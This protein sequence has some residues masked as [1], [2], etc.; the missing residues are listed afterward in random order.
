MLT[1]R[2]AVK[3]I[4]A[5]MAG[6]LIPQDYQMP[7]DM[8]GKRKK[9]RPEDIRSG[10]LYGQYQLRGSVL[11]IK[12]ASTTASGYMAFGTDMTTIPTS[13]TTGTGIYIDYTGIYGLASNVQ[14]AYMSAAD[15]KIYAGAGAVTLD[16]TGV[17]VLS[18]TSFSD[19]NSF[20][21]VESDGTID[22]LWQHY[23]NATTKNESLLKL[24]AL[25]GLASIFELNA[26]APST[27]QGQISLHTNSGT[28]DAYIQLT[29]T[30]SSTSR[31][32]LLNDSLAIKFQV[33]LV[34]D[35]VVCNSAAIATNATDGFL[36]IATCAGTPTGTPTTYTGRAPLV[37]DSTNNKL[38]IY[39][40][41][42]WVAVN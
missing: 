24:N 12:D 41:G 17:A 5:A 13:A 11:T 33:D 8:K 16:S 26:A 7:E 29:T 20:K 15:G 3:G 4:G 40:G 19:I 22:A 36:Y 38:Y 6:L 30:S 35:N 2:E 39:S 23:N 9:V 31:F 10:T 1:R 25:T 14:Q 32:Y 34:L 18:P 28:L 42:A 21:F 27:K 37:I